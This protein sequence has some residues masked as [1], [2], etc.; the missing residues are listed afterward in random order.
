MIQVVYLSSLLFGS[1]YGNPE[2]LKELIDAAHQRGL[3]VLLDIVHSH[4]SK[5]TVDGLNQFDGT[6]GCYFHNN[7]R[8]FHDL[9]DS[10]LFNYTEWEVLRFLLS[11]LRWW[12]EE[13]GF[14]GFRFDGTTSMLY[15]SHG[16]GRLPL[17][18]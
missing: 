3:V 15:H 12:I 2:E 5:N 17:F 11:N 9:W 14:D 16:L 13:Y 1:R 18:L 8:G 4:A 6:N 10:R 7:K